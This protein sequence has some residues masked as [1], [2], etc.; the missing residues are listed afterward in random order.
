MKPLKSIQQSWQEIVFIL[1]V[2]TLIFGITMNI[3]VAFQQVG[4]IVAY[5]IFVLVLICLISLLFKQRL[6]LGMCLAPIL[7]FCSFYGFIGWIIDKEVQGV[8]DIQ[9]LCLRILS[10]CFFAGLTL[11]AVSMFFKYIKNNDVEK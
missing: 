3:S 10:I 6:I 9:L 1:A 2:G 8:Q 7:G 4:N 11:T 5:C